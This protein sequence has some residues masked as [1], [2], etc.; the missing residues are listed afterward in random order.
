M[1]WQEC[2]QMTKRQEFVALVNC[3][4]ISMTE[5]CK[6]FGIS[7]K[8]GYKWRNRFAIDGEAGLANRSPR[9]RHSPTQTACEV[10]TPVVEL[11]KKNPAWSGR[12]LR[13]RLQ[14]LGHENVSA[15]ST[16]TNILHRH[17]LINPE[18]SK[19]HKAT[20]VLNI[21]SRTIFGKWISKA[22]LECRTRG[23]VIR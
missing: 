10:E 6:R 19:K 15:A 18:E 23:V 11:R 17:D 1:P 3:G 13:K 2:S 21:R 22:T 7:R 9:P 8:T 5:L 14:D 12:K 20:N 4:E 16:I